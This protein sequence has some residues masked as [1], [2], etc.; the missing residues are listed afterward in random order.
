M[1]RSEEC[2]CCKEYDR[3]SDIMSELQDPLPCITHHP[4]FSGICLNKWVLKV[5][6]LQCK[7]Q[8]GK[9][10]YEGPEHKLNRHIAYRQLARWCFG[11][12]GKE[13]LFALPSCAVCCIRPHFPP[14]GL[15]DEFESEGFHFYDE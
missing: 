1:A 4:G 11:I 3:V 6:W 5:A 7:Q 15:E 8:Y 13:I 2:K 12:L 14:P 9:T 10:V